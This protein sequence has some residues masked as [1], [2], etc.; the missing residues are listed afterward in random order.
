MPGIR[1]TLSWW[2]LKEGAKETVWRITACATLAFVIAPRIPPAGKA[3][4][5]YVVSD[6]ALTDRLHQAQ[7]AFAVE[8]HQFERERQH[9]LADERR[10]RE[11]I[12]ASFDRARLRESRTRTQ[13][14][15]SDARNEYPA[16]EAFLL[17]SAGT[18][19]PGD[20]ILNMVNRDIRNMVWASKRIS[21][22][23]EGQAIRDRIRVWIDGAH[24]SRAEATTGIQTID[25][26][27][28]AR[29]HSYS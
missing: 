25:L 28:F 13:T 27:R 23:Q 1:E 29:S 15:I 26:S 11:K 17:S 4:L 21:T 8:K 16:W 18:A 20:R 9:A 22:P 24:R 12:K 3:A 14:L 2:F 5:A 10:R 19:W 7:V 6:H